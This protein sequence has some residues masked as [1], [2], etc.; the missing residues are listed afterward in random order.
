MCVCASE[1]SQKTESIRRNWSEKASVRGGGCYRECVDQLLERESKGVWDHLRYE[2]DKWSFLFAQMFLICVWTS[3]CS[4]QQNRQS[5]C[6][7]VK[8]II[9]IFKL[10]Q[11]RITWNS[12]ATFW[13]WFKLFKCFEIFSMSHPCQRQLLL[14]GQLL[15]PHPLLLTCWR[16]CIWVPHTIW[17]IYNSQFF[18]TGF[19]YTLTEPWWVYGSV[20]CYTIMLVCFM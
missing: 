18:L 12:V 5:L 6:M 14:L 7:R 8:G 17:Q 10:Y 16:G 19:V 13:N 1:R 11:P 15:Q 2:I 9:K 3:D 20:L 4:C